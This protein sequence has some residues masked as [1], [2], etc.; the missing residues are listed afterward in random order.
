MSI[1]KFN[2]SEVRNLRRVWHCKA[3]MIHCK[4]TMI[5]CKGTMI[6]C[7]GTMTHC[8]GTIVEIHWVFAEIHLS[9]LKFNPS[10]VQNFRRVFQSIISPYIHNKTHRMSL[11]H[12]MG[13]FM[14][15]FLSLLKYINCV[16]NLLSGI[17]EQ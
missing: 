15:L 9:I 8:K 17:R 6:H 14:P 2:P 11:Q 7:K 13:L 10:E 3:T 5:H 16:L 1:L 4:A 12:L